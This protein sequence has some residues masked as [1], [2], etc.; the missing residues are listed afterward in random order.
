MVSALPL[1]TYE[2]YLEVALA[3]L[4][5]LRRQGEEALPALRATFKAAAQ[6]LQGYFPDTLD[7][8]FRWA[9]T[10]LP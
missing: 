6:L 7:R 3:R 8:S 2:D 9:V 1:Q 5:C 10:G 4:D